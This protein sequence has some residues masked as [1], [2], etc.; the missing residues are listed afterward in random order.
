MK[1]TALVANNNR[2]RFSKPLLKIIKS[3][4][5][6]RFK[7][8]QRD[9][10]LYPKGYN[11]MKVLSKKKIEI[12]SI[13]RKN[14][15]LEA[16]IREISIIL[17]K[18]YPKIHQAV[19]ELEKEDI[20][21]IKKVGK[22]SLCKINLSRET[23]SALLFLEEHEATSKKI[24]NINKILDFN[25]FIDDIIIV[26]GSY[27]N[28]VQTKKSDIDL[29]IITKENAFKKQKLLENMTL[30]FS[31]EIH[32]IVF[33]YKDFVDM[34]LSKEQNFGKEVFNNRIIFRSSERYYYLIKEAIKNGF[35]C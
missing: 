16:T 12:L 25:E 1:A 26:A 23:I 31:P 21:T 5:P 33:T 35:K 30:T 14:I 29:V 7:Y 6:T 11:K 8:T 20:L 17:K 2:T 3:I 27:A 10:I 34:L 24:P 4:T 22:S 18:A 28:G 13:F 9:I 19:K 15:F 32:P